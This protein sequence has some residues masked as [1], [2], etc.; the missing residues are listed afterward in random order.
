MKNQKQ[1]PLSNIASMNWNSLD[2]GKKS[3]F[4][5]GGWGTANDCFFLND[6]YDVW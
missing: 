5:L 1:L 2:Y 3:A 4:R 6:E